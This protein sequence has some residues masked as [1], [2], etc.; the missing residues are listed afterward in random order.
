[1]PIVSIAMVDGPLVPFDV[2]KPTTARLHDLALGGKDHYSVDRRLAAKLG[3]IYPAA[4]IIARDSRQFQIRA[5]DY[6]ARQG[7][8]Q[9]IDVGS[10]M[11]ASPATH[12]IAARVSPDARVAYVDNDPVV[13][14]HTAALLA[15]PGQVAAAPGDV[16]RP[17]DI[18]ARRE[19]AA[20]IDL[21]KPFCVILGMILDFVP[22]V[23]A[24]LLMAEFRDAMPAGSFLVL[25]IGIS[26]DAADIAREW[27]DVYR[28]AA[29]VHL[30]TREQIMG[31]FEGLEIIDPGF[32]EARCWRPAEPPAD[33]TPL[34]IDALACVGRKP[35]A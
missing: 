1:M 22:P 30:H 33:A 8:A 2:G 25:C 23:E 15:R 27:N 35:R 32:T 21:G 5:V 14:S 28:A 16:R 24:A 6:V 17:R 20:V 11:P 18:L 4:A 31:Y 3:G 29:E 10:G 12:E 26:N 9:F 13:I 19:L 34:P 7:V